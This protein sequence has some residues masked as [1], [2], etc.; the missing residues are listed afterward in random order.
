[1]GVPVFPTTE[2]PLRI[3][4]RMLSAAL[5][6]ACTLGAPALG[7]LPQ[8]SGTVDLLT[9]ANVRLDGAAANHQ[10]AS[11]VAGAG[12]VNGDGRDDVIV[13]AFAAGNNG[14]MGSG[15]AYVLFGSASPVNVDLGA[16]GSA[17]FRIDGAAAND[18]AGT[19]V[20]SAGDVNG[21]GRGDVIVGAWGAGH[22]GRTASGSA[23]VVFGSASPA[24]VDLGS[25]GAAGFRIDGVAMSDRTG[26]SVAGVGD[27]NGDGRDDVIVGAHGTDNNGRGDSGSAHVVF[28]SASPVNVDL[29]SPGA[30][31]FRIDGAAAGDR[32]GITVAGAGDVNGD[33]RDDVIVGA[34]QAGNNGRAVSGSAYVVFGSVSPVNVDLASLGAAGFRIDGAATFDG[35]RASA[36]AGDM[37]G[38]GRDDVI[39]GAEGADNNGRAGSGS[40]Y[41]VFG[42]ASPVGVDLAALGSAGFRIDGAAGSGG[43][44]YSV[45]AAGDVNGDGRDD[46]IVGAYLADNNGRTNSGSAYVVFGSASPVGVDLAALGAAGFRIDG[47]AAEDLAGI[48]VAGAGD[49]NGDGRDDV[50][51]GAY[52]A[53]NNG[54]GASGSAYVTYGF[55]APTA[56]Y[57]ALSATIGVPITPHGPTGV[58]R[59]GVPS[60]SVSPALPAGLSMDPVTGVITGTPSGPLATTSHVV[61]MTDLAGVVTPI[62]EVTVSA[63]PEVPAPPSEP[64]PPSDPAPPAAP[65]P[66]PDTRAPRITLQVPSGLRAGPRVRV[67]VRCDEDCRLVG[68]AGGAATTLDLRA[69]RW[70]WVPLSLARSAPAARIGGTVRVRLEAT[71][72]AGNRSVLTRTF[73]TLRAVRQAR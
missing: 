49:L 52:V 36:G 34:D 37:N 31:A 5:L 26:F 73:S 48:S 9:Q 47:A 65:A 72:A 11:S 38:D 29:A 20:A 25:L 40:A 30:A 62:L 13:G 15:S 8:Q 60:F 59:T 12:D 33:G 63:V 6:S 16:L 56:S 10:A 18:L 68:R 23:Y 7:A 67:R 70:E 51:M 69:G 4:V 28:G 50:I 19:S 21:D 17:G 54:R 32:T 45:A 14:R 2:P 43:A 22:N 1:M 46:V 58:A 39:V 53:D 41:V 24:N 61:T 66:A 57:G 42:S 55:G 27:V 64:A 44:G 3:P 71:D 35:V